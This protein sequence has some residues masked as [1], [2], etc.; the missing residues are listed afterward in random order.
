MRFSVRS[1]RLRERGRH[2]QARVA[3]WVGADGTPRHE[4]QCAVHFHSVSNAP[5]RH[6][7]ARVAVWVGA[8]GTPRHEWQCAVHCHSISNAPKLTPR[9]E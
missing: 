1:C 8:D 9:G 4:W 7:Q 3:V 6:A 2:A 5:K